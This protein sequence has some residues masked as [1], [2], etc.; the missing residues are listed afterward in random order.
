MKIIGTIN[1][2]IFFIFINIFT[3]CTK[4]VQP[5]KITQPIYK[6]KLQP[7]H[8]VKI[9]EKPKIESITIETVKENNIS[10]E[11]NTSDSIIDINLTT[12]FDNNISTDINSS[13][14]NVSMDINTSDINISDEN[15]ST[16]AIMFPSNIIGKYAINATNSMISYLFSQNKSFKLKVFDSITE[17]KDAILDIFEEL[18][19]KNITKVLMLSTYTGVQHIQSIEDIEKYDIYLPLIDKSILDLNLTNVVYGS[20]SYKKQFDSLLKYSKTNIVEFYDKSNLGRR[21]NYTL[22]SYD[23]SEQNTSIVYSK[24]INNDNAEYS[25]LLKKRTKYLSDSTLI[26]NMP[27]VKSSIILSQIHAHDIN[28]SN[29][30]ST[31]LNYTPLLFSLTQIE[32]RNNM[33]IANSIGKIDNQ[34][35]EYNALLDNDTRY[36]WVNYSTIIGTQYLINK[37]ISTFDSIILNENQIEYPVYIYKTT[38]YS[39][40]RL[41]RY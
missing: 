8:I 41:N 18:K 5:V 11:N 1:I 31:Q 15:I 25:K 35:E 23:L 4:S 28:I 33:L 12:V 22:D 3:G 29:I 34:I 40:K 32:D 14:L 10:L 7:V 26:I 13:D 9:Q 39:F 6:A 17:D 19:T 20:I 2:V 30:L 27:I 21:L 37:D 24:E 16:I 38:K 36:N